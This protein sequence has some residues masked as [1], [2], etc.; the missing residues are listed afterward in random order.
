[1]DF[2]MPWLCNE[3]SIRW[4]NLPY[5]LLHICSTHSNTFAPALTK[6]SKVMSPPGTDTL[7]VA[8]VAGL[9]SGTFEEVS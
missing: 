3:G 7:P 6:I 9:P 8:L 4:P 2:E 1:M 5:G